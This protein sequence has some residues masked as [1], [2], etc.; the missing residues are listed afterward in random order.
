MGK[1]LPLTP[2]CEPL[3]PPDCNSLFEM[4]EYLLAAAYSGL[5]GY[6]SPP[7]SPCAGGLD[8]IVSLGQPSVDMCDVLIVWLVNYGP[9]PSDLS[10]AQRSVGNDLFAPQWTATWQFELWEASYPT[11]EVEGGTRVSLPS[12]GALH[13]INRHVYAHGVSMYHATLEA[14][15][16]GSL[17]PDGARCDKQ[18]FT[19]LTPLSPQ[20]ACAGWMFQSV[21][22]IPWIADC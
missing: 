12:L 2:G 22:P 5:I 8:V 13:E 16:D 6:E 17:W 11:I 4:G 19:N 9:K 15:T 18:T 14:N 1:L 3:D 10:H 7:D 21:G 20:G